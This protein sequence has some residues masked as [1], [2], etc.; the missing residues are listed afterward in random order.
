MK[1]AIGGGTGFIGGRLIRYL[2]QCGDEIIIISRSATGGTRDGLKAIAW[3]DLLSR[4]EELE[5]L[6]AIVN[7]SG[8]TINQRWTKQAKRRVLESRLDT[9]AKL[10]ELVRALRV[11]PKAVL[12]GSGMSIY[13]TS[14]TARFDESSPANVVDFLSSVVVAWE[15]AADAI[16]APRLIKL[17]IGLVL[18]ADGGALPLMSMPYRFGVGGRVGSGRQI[19][20]WIHADDM[21]RLIRFCIESEEISGPVNATA[22]NPVTN[23]EF[24]RALARAM[25]RP[26]WL[27]VPEAVFRLAFG[28]MADLLLTG[29][30][31]K[32]SVLLKH[33]FQFRYPTADQALQAI[34]DK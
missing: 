11:K 19:V 3:D 31:V 4:K 8:E 33:G 10:A 28:E 29:Q 32:P 27:P 20:S 22:P 30:Y 16:P 34:F 5:G 2:Q 1:I 9:A 6:D 12:N 26:H 25:R 14:E 7:L 17:R 23:D 24:G 18:A 21:A 15:K 13:G